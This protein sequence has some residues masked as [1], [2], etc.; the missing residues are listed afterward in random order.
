MHAREAAMTTETAHRDIGGVLLAGGLSRRDA[1]TAVA[2][3]YGLPKREVYDL[4][5]RTSPPRSPR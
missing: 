3:R 4:V 2:R 5:V 1:I